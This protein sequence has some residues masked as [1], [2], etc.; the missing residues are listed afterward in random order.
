[1]GDRSL[2]VELGDSIDPLINQKV[3]E[4]FLLLDTYRLDGVVDLVPS[5]RSLMVTYNPL[6]LVRSEL[7]DWITAVEKER[8]LSR[9][10]EPKTIQV[11]V[12]YGGEYGPDLEWVARFHNLSP[13]EVIQIHTSR[14]YRVYMIGFTP[15]HPYLGELPAKLRTPRKETPRTSVPQGSVGI[16]QKQIVIYPV[17]SPGGF[18]TIGQ[19]PLNLF[20]PDKQPPSL[21]S[22][23]DRVEF[24]S[25]T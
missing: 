5:Y 8:R 23:G 6:K 1:M 10:A 16:A 19:T 25:V 22:M 20:D 18:Q 12:Q 21:L 7:K 15:G 24:V 9:P 2:L 14:L 13:K 11:P 17:P 4:L 3:Q